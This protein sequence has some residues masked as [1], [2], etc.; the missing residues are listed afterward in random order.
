VDSAWE[1]FGAEA[2]EDVLFWRNVSIPVKESCSKFQN[3]K[4]NIMEEQ[5]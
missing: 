5:L 1:A 2:I 4:L 3:K